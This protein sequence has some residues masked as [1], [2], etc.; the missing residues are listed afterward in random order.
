MLSKIEVVS[1]EGI[2]R[3]PQAPLMG[4]PQTLDG[5]TLGILDNHKEFSDWVL[6]HVRACLEAR[7]AFKAV[8]Q[9]QKHH[10]AQPAAAQLL[11]ALTTPCDVILVG[12]GH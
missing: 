3:I 2:S 9:L 11:Q 12:V 1:P 5:C 4:R 8:M 6:A 10:L 7:F